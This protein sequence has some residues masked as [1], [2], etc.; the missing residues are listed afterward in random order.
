MESLNSDETCQ[1]IFSFGGLQSQLCQI[2]QE[3]ITK[4][5]CCGYSIQLHQGIT[6]YRLMLFQLIDR[7]QGF[8]WMMTPN[9]V[10]VILSYTAHV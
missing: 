3:S 5:Q 1:S 7:Y 4:K 10:A 2:T 8:L 6:L 9:F